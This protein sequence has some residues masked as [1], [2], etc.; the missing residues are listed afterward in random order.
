[1]QN[2]FRILLC[3][4]L[5]GLFSGF[6]I[7]TTSVNNVPIGIAVTVI[8]CI[9]GLSAIIPANKLIQQKEKEKED[10]IRRLEEEVEALKRI[11][12][13]KDEQE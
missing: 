11:K 1:M 5:I 7:C 2:A 8:G 9:F 4:C 6:F 3:F 10:R 13:E 12:N